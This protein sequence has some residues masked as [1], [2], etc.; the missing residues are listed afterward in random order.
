MEARKQTSSQTIGPFFAFSLASRQYGYKFASTISNVLA[1]EKTPGEKIRLQGHVFDGAG[2]VVTDALIEIWQA[3]SSGLYGSGA[4]GDSGFGGF[5]RA[6]TGA[7]SSKRFW[8]D[9]VKPG[10]TSDG[11]SPHINMIVFMRGLLTHLFTRVYF[12]DEEAANAADPVLQ[13]VEPDRRDTLVARRI[14]SPAGLTYEFD[15]RMQGQ[16]ETVFFDV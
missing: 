4:E 7:Q 9:T 3:D 16:R 11:Q 10:A 14:D 1:D 6:G 8:F 13:S 15:I 5:G 2:A 12:P